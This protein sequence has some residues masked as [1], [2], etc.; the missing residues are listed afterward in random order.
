MLNI[1]STNSPFGNYRTGYSKSGP[2]VKVEIYSGRGPRRYRVTYGRSQ[3]NEAQGITGRLVG[4]FPT[5]KAVSAH[6][7]TI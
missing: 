6:L 4:C 2:I 5:L 7:E 1:E 3:N